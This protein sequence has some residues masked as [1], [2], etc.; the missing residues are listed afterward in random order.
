[1]R[2]ISS[3]KIGNL[4]TKRSLTLGRLWGEGVEGGGTVTLNELEF[5]ARQ[6]SRFLFIIGLITILAKIILALLQ[7]ACR[8][9]WILL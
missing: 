1:V 4:R 8:N 3:G 9:S 6:Y 5:N 7:V 2:C